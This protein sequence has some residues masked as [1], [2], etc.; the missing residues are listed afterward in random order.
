MPWIQVRFEVSKSLAN[1][2]EQLLFTIGAQS[3]S[4]LEPEN[5]DLY[6]LSPHSYPMWEVPI[7]VG[8]FKADEQVDELVNH[9][10]GVYESETHS[11]FPNY[12]IEILEDQQWETAWAK[13]STPISIGSRLWIQPS[14]LLEENTL[15]MPII[16]EQESNEQG[17]IILTLDPGLA[18]GTGSHPTTG[19]CLEWLEQESYKPSFTDKTLC[20]YGTGSGILGIAALKLGIKSLW[21]TDIDPQAITETRKNAEINQILPTL[22]TA[23]LANQLPKLTFDIVMANILA[24]PLL[25]L[26]ER[27]QSLVASQGI[28]V[29]SGILE[30]Q[31]EE[32]IDCY[33][34][35]FNL[36]PYVASNGWV[37]IEG[38][39][40]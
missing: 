27:L 11:R 26:G 3:V 17:P 2:F 4:F 35:W 34:K 18:F 16:N 22:Y 32:I 5:Q 24:N 37:R 13:F 25:D 15:A 8:L 23:V 6:E 9:L 14:Q 1:T 39:K 7:L 29:M 10:K 28:L 30:H 33:Q 20:D 21:S 31:A 19:L 36:E 12:H 40:K 38:Q